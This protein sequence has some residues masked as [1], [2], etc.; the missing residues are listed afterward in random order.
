[1]QY[2]ICTHPG[3]R[4]AAVPPLGVQSDRCGQSFR[5]VAVPSGRGLQPWELN[6]RIINPN[7]PPRYL[8]TFPAPSVMLPTGSDRRQS[9]H[10]SHRYIS[11][12]GGLLQSWG[13]PPCRPGR[14][15]PRSLCCSKCTKIDHIRTYISLYVR[16][17]THCTD[18]PPI[19]TYPYPS[20]R[21]LYYLG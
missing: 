1:M 17:I 3:T 16:G 21:G 2:S 18:P 10:Q 15:V 8:P 6:L 9:Y 20:R 4:P 12:C 11:R 5:V 13:T 7:P 19:R 14:P